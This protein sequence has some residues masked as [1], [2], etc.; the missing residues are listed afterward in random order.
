[1]AAVPAHASAP[2]DL[3]GPWPSSQVRT[4]ASER[5]LLG[6]SPNAAPASC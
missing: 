6:C 5:Q 2:Y 3:T 1:M 4:M